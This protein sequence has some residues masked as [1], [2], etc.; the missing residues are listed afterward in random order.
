MLCRALSC[1]WPG[2]AHGDL[3]G[4]QQL[5]AGGTWGAQAPQPIFASLPVVFFSPF[6]LHAQR[7]AGPS[8]APPRLVLPASPAAQP[9]TPQGTLETHH[10][11]VFR[12]RLH[13]HLRHHLELGRLDTPVQRPLPPS[14]QPLL[15]STVQLLSLF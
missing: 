7:I 11:H 3:L 9:Q 4:H 8:P 10:C 15:G 6:P 14:A 12:G 13:L 5:W 2:R 1:P